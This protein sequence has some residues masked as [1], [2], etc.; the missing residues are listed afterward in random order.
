MKII[1][2]LFL[3]TTAAFATESQDAYQ[4]KIETTIT[5]KPSTTETIDFT[6]Y[7]KHPEKKVS[8]FYETKG[9][10]YLNEFF[11]PH[12]V[13]SKDEK[14]M[15]YL[16]VI[17]GKLPDPK[18]GASLNNMEYGFKKVDDVIT[19]YQNDPADPKVHLYTMKIQLLHKNNI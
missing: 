11:P 12:E 18:V 1:P 17:S 8:R 16:P 13:L 6:D 14:K 2:I 15:I 10:I 4:V 7:V 3:F 19:V 9:G 5:G